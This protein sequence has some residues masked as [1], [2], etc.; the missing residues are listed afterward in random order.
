MEELN[1][2]DAELAA[3][4]AA[5]EQRTAKL[6]GFAAELDKREA[7]VVQREAVLQQQREQMTATAQL[8]Q[9]E[10]EVCMPMNL[11]SIIC[12]HPTQSELLLASCSLKLQL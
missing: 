8:T 7:E 4:A 2:K 1:A 12:H 6:E 5:I 9:R 3:A 10:A 11:N